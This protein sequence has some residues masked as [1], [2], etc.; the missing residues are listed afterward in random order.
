LLT[1]E[2]DHS[3]GSLNPLATPVLVT[4]SMHVPLWHTAGLLMWLKQRHQESPP[5]SPSL[6]FTGVSMAEKEGGAMTFSGSLHCPQSARGPRHGGP[7]CSWDVN[8]DMSSVEGYNEGTRRC[9]LFFIAR[10]YSG[11]PCLHS[12]RQL[13]LSEDSWLPHTQQ[14]VANH[15]GMAHPPR[16]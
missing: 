16:T 7:H 6:A 1:D 11:S 12:G 13:L 8:G 2:R 3:A 10:W 15:F 14:S 4:S 5:D 9:C